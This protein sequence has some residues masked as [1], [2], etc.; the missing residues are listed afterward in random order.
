MER[1][2][3]LDKNGITAGIGDPD[4]LIIY[5]IM[6]YRKDH[7]EHKC[8][9]KKHKKSQSMIDPDPG[10]IGSDAEDK[11]GKIAC[12]EIYAVIG[13]DRGINGTG[14]RD[15]QISEIGYND[16]THKENGVNI[17]THTGF[18]QKNDIEDR[19]DECDQI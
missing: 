7:S 3:F 10:H 16:G 2:V 9:K 5:G 15:T 8:G 4:I 17:G 6:P 19:K 13:N 1:T 18:N 12:T 11:K 14:N